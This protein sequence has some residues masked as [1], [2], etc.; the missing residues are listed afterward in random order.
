MRREFTT[1]RIARA[2]A[3]VLGNAVQGFFRFVDRSTIG[4]LGAGAC[5]ADTGA[6]GVAERNGPCQMNVYITNGEHSN[7]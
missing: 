2:H 7:V 1:L 5:N 3:E 4:R 6:T